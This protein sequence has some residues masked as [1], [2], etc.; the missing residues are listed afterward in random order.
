MNYFFLNMFFL[1]ILT[2]L[3][4]MSF[5]NYVKQQVKI[6][7]LIWGKKELGKSLSTGQIRIF[8]FI[9]NPD[10]PIELQS[11]NL[12]KDPEENGTG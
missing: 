1:K 3:L 5:T 8:R 11:R 6:S 2:P 4:S 12:A 10:Y 7:C 9:S